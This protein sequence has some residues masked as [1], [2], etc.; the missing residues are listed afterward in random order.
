[1]TQKYPDELDNYF[2]NALKFFF[3]FIVADLFLNNQIKLNKKKEE[4][5]IR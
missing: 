3:F 2:Q 1:L 4:N 5:L